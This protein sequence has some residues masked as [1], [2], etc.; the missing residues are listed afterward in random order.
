MDN[1]ELVLNG[2]II[3]E[4]DKLSVIHLATDLDKSWNERN[5]GAF[6]ELFAPDSD[7]RF[8]TGV[9]IIG[10]DSIE[11]YWRDQVFAG[12]PQD[13]KHESTIKRVRFISDNLAI[14]DGTIR[15]VSLIEGKERLHLD[16]EVTAVAIKKDG[17]W[18]FSAV[19][20]TALAVE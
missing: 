10:K 18:Y 4:E 5:A 12:I 19:R 8:H 16:S 11:K 9:W 14:G 7:F 1:I 15:I 13:L 2:L 20:L 6:A 3:T 17:R